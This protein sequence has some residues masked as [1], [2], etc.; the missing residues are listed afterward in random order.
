MNIPFVIAPVETLIGIAGVNDVEFHKKI[1]LAVKQSTKDSLFKDLSLT[2]TEKKKELEFVENF[3][4]AS[5]WG[6]IQGIDVQFEGKKAIVVVENS[7]F[8]SA[9][10]GKLTFPVDAF[11]RG[12]LAGIFSKLFEEDIDCVEVECQALTSERCKFILKP[13][14]EFDF[15]NAIVGQQLTHE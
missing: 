4:T 9:L 2:F 10:K 8:A 7:P 5:G 11:L 12:T 13:K 6:A 1:Y 14:T 15:A 3:F